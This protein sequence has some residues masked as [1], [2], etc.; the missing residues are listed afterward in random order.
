[1]KIFSTLKLNSFSNLRKAR[2][3]AFC[4][5]LGIIPSLSAATYKAEDRPWYHFIREKMPQTKIPAIE[6]FSLSNG[7]KVYFLRSETVP[8]VTLQIFI[9]G[10]AFEVADEKLGLQGLWG[11]TVVFSGSDALGRDALSAYLE[12][13]ATS[14]SY[15]AGSARSAFNVVSMAHYFSRDVETLFQVLSEPRFAA[16]DFSLLKT[17]AL[18]LLTRRDE[19]PAKWAAL[20]MAKLYWGDSVRGRYATERTV[21]AVERDDLVSW[22]KKNWR[23][24][25]LTLAVTGDIK[26]SALENL[27]NRTFGTMPFDKNLAPDMTKMHILSRGKPNTVHLLEKEIPQTTVLY[28]APGIKHNA[29]DYYALRLFD[30]LLG[31]DSFNSYLMQ[32]IR[33]EKG[34][35]YTAYSSYE[36]DDFTGSLLLFTQTANA[37]LSD[38]IGLTDSIL[39]KPEAFVTA[40]KI[41]E[42]KIALRNKFV[43]L[44][45]KP[46]EY[47]KSYLQLKWD[48]LPPTYLEN[49]VSN[50][51][52]VTEKD[53]LRIART[54]YK[55]ENF[56]ILLCGPKENY[57]K[58]SPIRPGVTENLV[59]EK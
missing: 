31:G 32:K 43:F 52:R 41:A 9:D 49:Y 56:T 22:Q 34:W 24:E 55:P 29:S 1:M 33:T 27:L 25:R 6:E 45:E 40:E 5:S 54:Y 50:L 19:N 8:L 16:E 42:A 21:K 26:K 30:F 10:G 44:F 46:A 12:G 58:V 48:G 17:R 15:A 59:L 14:F 11:E 53:I 57:R 3:F 47:L 39:A 37:S 35:A 23:G 4:L 38:V 18:Q 7:V 2:L 13:R 36:T 28:K 51:D 20:G